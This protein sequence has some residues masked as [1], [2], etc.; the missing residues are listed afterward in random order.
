MPRVHRGCAGSVSAPGDA[1][2]GGSARWGLSA[3]PGGAAG[4]PA[5][6]G[7]SGEVPV[8]RCC[9]WELPSWQVEHTSAWVVKL[10]ASCA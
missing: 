7:S 6:R 2:H 3:E 1:G 9:C 5:G 8:L 4:D 10:S